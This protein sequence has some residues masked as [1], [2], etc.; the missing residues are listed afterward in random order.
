MQTLAMSNMVR[1]LLVL[2]A[3][4]FLGACQRGPI[5]NAPYILVG[6]SC[7]LDADSNRVCDTDEAQQPQAQRADHIECDFPEE[8]PCSEGGLDWEAGTLTVWLKNNVGYPI[9]VTRDVTATSAC[10]D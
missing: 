8:L 10:K 9:T 1:L 7:C 5:C 4:L 2:A 3:V 6:T